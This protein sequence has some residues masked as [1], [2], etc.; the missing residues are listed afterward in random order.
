MAY[1]SPSTHSGIEYS[2]GTPL[3]INSHSMSNF[4]QAHPVML[5]EAKTYNFNSTCCGCYEDHQDAVLS[6]TSLSIARRLGCACCLTSDV[7]VINLKHV[8]SAQVSHPMG[9]CGLFLG[10]FFFGCFGWHRFCAGRPRTGFLM[11]FLFIAALAV[12][13]MGFIIM[14]DNDNSSRFFGYN[15]LFLGIAGSIAVA[16]LLFFWIVDAFYLRGWSQYVLL[17]ALAKGDGV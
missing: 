6:P 10:W 5:P 12:T 8:E 13:P 3:I 4:Q 1:A 14:D 11:L 16:L 2:E 9:C 17:F 7:T 15:W